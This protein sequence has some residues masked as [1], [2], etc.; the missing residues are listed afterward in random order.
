MRHRPRQ[1]SEHQY[2]FAAGA[3]DWEVYKTIL[4]KS[5]KTALDCHLSTDIEPSEVD[6]IYASTSTLRTSPAYTLQSGFEPRAGVDT[7]VGNQALKY[8]SHAWSIMD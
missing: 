5:F 4:S 8:R 7:I 3:K 2:L 6:Y 1:Q